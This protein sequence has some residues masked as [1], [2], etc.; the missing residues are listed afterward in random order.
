MFMRFFYEIFFKYKMV[1]TSQKE[2]EF[3]DI[4]RY[5]AIKFG[6]LF[7]EL[8]DLVGGKHE[9]ILVNINIK[10]NQ[11]FSLRLSCIYVHVLIVI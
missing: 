4:Y 1:N 10:E 6:I 5:Q 2:V 11:E 8:Y 9:T 7:Q 3:S